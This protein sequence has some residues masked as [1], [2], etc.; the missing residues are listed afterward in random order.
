MKI[1][2]RKDMDYGINKTISNII[3]LGNCIKIRNS[4]KIFQVI[5]INKTKNICWVREW[6]LNFE[7]YETF[8]LSIKN[9]MISIT[10]EIKN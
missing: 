1:A 5:G 10:C 6:P 2:N 9:V 7:E 4:E 8:T 3:D